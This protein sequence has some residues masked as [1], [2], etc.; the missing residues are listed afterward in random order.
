M[1]TKIV[2]RILDAAGALLGWTPLLAEARGDQTLRASHV[3]VVPIEQSGTA[4]VVSY[5][6]ADIGVQKR[7]PFGPV[8]LFEGALIELK[9]PD[10]VVLTLPSDEGP[11]PA[12]TVRASTA[13]SPPTAAM[14]VLDARLLVS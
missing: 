9:F 12:V 6:W 3:C 4:T 14:G 8:D 1:R 7:V 5:H 11:L 13:L 2:V 10:G